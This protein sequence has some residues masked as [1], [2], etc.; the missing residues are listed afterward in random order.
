MGRVAKWNPWHEIK[1]WSITC[2]TFEFDLQDKSEILRRL[3]SGA[4]YLRAAGFHMPS[5]FV[6]PHDKISRS[7]YNEIQR[8]FRVV[9]TGWFE[10]RRL[11]HAWWPMYAWR[12]IRKRSHWRVGNTLLL[13]HPG[14]LLSRHR[15]YEQILDSVR[16][17]VNSA[18]LTVLVT[19]WWEY[20]PTQKTDE[21]L[22]GILHETA[23]FLANDPTMRVISFDE[24]PGHWSAVCP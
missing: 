22:I 1:I 12:K 19:H 7:S 9:S 10:L 2:D 15:P 23:E 14:C 4:N 18:K 20:F 11:P 16:R 17:A 5:T 21:R 3:D 13:S 8:R 6:A 24:L